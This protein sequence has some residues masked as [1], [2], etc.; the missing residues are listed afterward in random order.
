MRG[1]AQRVAGPAWQFRRLANSSEKSR[2]LLYPNLVN[3]D[4]TVRK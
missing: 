4:V 1:K 2:V 3:S